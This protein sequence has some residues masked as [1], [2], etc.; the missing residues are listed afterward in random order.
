MLRH[1]L[2]A[3]SATGRWLDHVNS[4]AAIGM[5]AI[6]SQRA[7]IQ[8]QTQQGDV[9]RIDYGSR[10]EVRASAAQVASKDGTTSTSQI[11]ASQRERF[12]VSV[13]GDL[14]ADELQAIDDVLAKINTLADDFFSGN[15][16]A[17]FARATQFDFDSGALA[18]VDVRLSQRQQVSVAYANGATDSP[19]NNSPLVPAAPAS[20]NIAVPPVI[21]AALPAKAMVPTEISALGAATAKAVAASASVHSEKAGAAASS[22]TETSAALV[23]YLAKIKTSLQATPNEAQLGFSYQTKL[24]LLI[25]VVAAKAPSSVAV[26]DAASTALANAA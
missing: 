17:S 23:N 3:M 14:N 21:A 16:A 2:G 11:A 18:G 5:H 6:S 15:T 13:Q 25:M 7:G 10:L 19:A 24:A 22:Q 8:I 20:T 4:T 26:N 1:A 12:S 9:I